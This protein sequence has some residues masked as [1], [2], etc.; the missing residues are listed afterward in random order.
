[1]Y[2][3]LILLM[4]AFGS[5][6]LNSLAQQPYSMRY[7]CYQTFRALPGKQASG[8]SNGSWSKSSAT[9][10]KVDFNVGSNKNLEI[11]QGGQ[12]ITFVRIG[13]PLVSD[14]EKGV[15]YQLIRTRYAGTEY[16]FQYF[17]NFNFRMFSTE[18]KNMI[19][20][21]C[22]EPLKANEDIRTKTYKISTKRAFFYKQPDLQFRRTAFLIYGQVVEA[23]ADENGFV[24][25]TFI[26]GNDVKTSGWL[27]KSDLI[28]Y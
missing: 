7:T 6:P 16:L 12:K 20:Y 18:N 28:K 23:L 5:Y 19:E 10:Y 3:T 2:K 9:D 13:E 26:N 4:I 24:F 25:V 1:M 17:E 15:K 21:S 8:A 22:V 27:L 11:T 14:T